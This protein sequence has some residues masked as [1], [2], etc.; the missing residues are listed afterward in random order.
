[1]IFALSASALIG[2]VMPA[3]TPAVLATVTIGGSGALL[4]YVLSARALKIG[5]LR[6]LTGVLRARLSR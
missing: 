2:T 4:L 6:E 3:S 5:E 1:M